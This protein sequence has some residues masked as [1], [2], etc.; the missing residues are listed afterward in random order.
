M[1]NYVENKKKIEEIRD[2]YGEY[3]FR[4]GIS[5]LMDVG[6]RHLTKENV[7]K[8]LKCIEENNLQHKLGNDYIALKDAQ[9]A[10]KIAENRFKK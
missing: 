8:M 10:I 5:H 7:E 1:S 9:K 4:G 6:I 2:R 3:V